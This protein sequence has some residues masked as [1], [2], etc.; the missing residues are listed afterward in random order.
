MSFARPPIPPDEEQRLR[1]L[2]E[3][4]LLD[5]EAEERFDRITRLVQRILDVPMSAITLIDEDRQWFKS[6]QGLDYAEGPREEAFCAHAVAQDQTLYVP[7]A[8]EDERFAENPAVLEN[9]NVRSYAGAQI[10]APDGATIG[11]LCAI[12]SRPRELSDEDL[13]ALEDLAR[14]AEK[15]IEALELAQTDPL[16]GLAN[17][18]GL[19]AVG[20]QMLSVAERMRFPAELLYLDVDG[21]KPVNDDLGHDQGDRLL[22]DVAELLTD[23]FRESDVIARLGGDE[24]CALLS[25][26]AAAG[27]ENAIVRLQGAID[28]HN[29]A[30]GRPYQ[31]SISVGHAGFEAGTDT[32]LETMLRD[33]DAA[34]YEAKRRRR[35]QS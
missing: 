12:D 15:E 20:S 32:G 4:G 10:H 1:S 19:L 31:V 25:G 2:R 7:D 28:Q 11:T 29:D 9:P 14:M 35:G 22:T 13:Q 34:M 3:L 17:R 26:T 18:R 16:T 6:R 8:L 5:S 24:F 23:T 30:S 21:L 27:A 33:A